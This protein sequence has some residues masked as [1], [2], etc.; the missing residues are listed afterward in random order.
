MLDQIAE[1]IGKY[2]TL[3]TLEGWIYLVGNSKELQE[4]ISRIY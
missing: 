1:N 3:R 4:N 2:A